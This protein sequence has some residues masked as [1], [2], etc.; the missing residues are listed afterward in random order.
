MPS[1]IPPHPTKKIKGNKENISQHTTEAAYSWQDMQIIFA[2]KKKKK[3][4][5]KLQGILSSILAGLKVKPKDQGRS[6][7]KC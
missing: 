1:P 3:D 6:G 7:G 5:C 4:P 2:L